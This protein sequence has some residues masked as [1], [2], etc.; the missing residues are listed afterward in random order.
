MPLKCIKCGSDKRT[1]VGDAN[2]F[3]Y[4][5]IVN[6]KCGNKECGAEWQE[7]FIM[8]QKN[9]KTQNKTERHLVNA[10]NPNRNCP[11][12]DNEFVTVT[13]DVDAGVDT[14]GVS[15]E[16]ATTDKVKGCG[17]KYEEHYSIDKIL[18]SKTGK[19]IKL[20]QRTLDEKP[21]K[22]KVKTKPKPK[23]AVKAAKMAKPENHTKK[24]LDKKPSKPVVLGATSANK[25]IKSSND[26]LI[27]KRQKEREQRAKKRNKA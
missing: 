19:E 8:I 24:D 2:F 4:P 9:I 3:E 10:K 13:G 7:Q 1:V 5:T 17:A 21:E 23:K 15:I 22:I 20:E 14:M 18:D 26:K 16:C 11:K 27:Q 6:L 25:Y 12:C